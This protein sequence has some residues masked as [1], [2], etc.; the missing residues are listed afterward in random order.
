MTV[1][2]RTSLPRLRTAIEPPVA[3]RTGSPAANTTCD[4]VLHR[5]GAGQ[6]E[7]DLGQAGQPTGG[8]L[9]WRAPRRRAPA[10]ARVEVGLDLLDAPAPLLAGRACAAGPVALA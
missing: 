9:A 7:R 10:H 8:Q 5:G 6:R 4:E 1:T 2:C 3:P